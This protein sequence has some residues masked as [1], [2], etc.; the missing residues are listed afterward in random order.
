MI[1]DRAVERCGGASEAASGSAIAVAW[2]GIAAGMVV[3]EHE[4]EQ[5]IGEQA[6]AIADP[7]GGT[8]IDSEARTAVA[9]ILSAI[10]QHGLIASE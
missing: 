8:V 1:D 2:G 5:V 3:G 4:G 10:R 9:E 6:A 7:A